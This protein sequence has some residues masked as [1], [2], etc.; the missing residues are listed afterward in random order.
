MITHVAIKCRGRVFSL[1]KPNRHCHVLWDIA[2]TVGWPQL[3]EDVQGFL[4]DKGTFMD[5]K[6]ARTHALACGQ[7][8][9]AFPKLLE[10]YSEDLW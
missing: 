3:G 8:F 1:P 9:R 5:R 10:L 6:E 4:D 2:E 7:D